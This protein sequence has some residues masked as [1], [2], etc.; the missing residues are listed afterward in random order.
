MSL[1]THNLTQFIIINTNKYLIKNLLRKIFIIAEYN[2]I[3][4]F[5]IVF[6]K[7]L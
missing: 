2:F 6:L 7:Y 3:N 1:N 4:T 5:I